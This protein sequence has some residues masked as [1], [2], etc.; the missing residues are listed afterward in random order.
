MNKIARSISMVLILA[1][2]M[3]SCGISQH[4]FGGG[5]SADQQFRIVPASRDSILVSP[6]TKHF[7]RYVFTGDEWTMTPEWALGNLTH[8]RIEVVEAWYYP[9]SSHTNFGNDAWGAT[10]IRPLFVVG[11]AEDDSEILIHHYVG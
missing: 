7:Y 4:P 9:G 1:F 3:Y 5:Y 10:I 6:L 2:N 8:L 11:L